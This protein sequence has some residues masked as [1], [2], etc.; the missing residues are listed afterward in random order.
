MKPLVSIGMPVKNGFIN[1]T[2][3]EI[4]L[5]KSLNS[6]LNQ[7]YDNLEIIISNSHSTDETKDFIEKASRLDKRI[8]IFDQTNNI[9]AAQNFEFVF[10]KANGKYFKWQA[11]DDIIS[12]NFIEK[13]LIFLE[14]NQDYICSSSKFY[15]EDNE[16]EIYSADLDE[17]LYK[18]LK[19]F[20]NIRFCSHN[21]FY[22]LIKKEYV[23]KTRYLSRD[24][25]A[26]DWMFDLELLLHGKFKTISE[27]YMILGAK[28]ISK[29]P[30]FL[31]EERFNNKII[32][33]YLPFY[34]FTKDLIMKTIFLDNLSIYQKISI[35]YSCLK[36]NL[37][38]LIKHRMN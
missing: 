4:N 33:R 26:W 15:W 22:G 8:K 3:N 36:T 28:G 38:F 5:F 9:S 17:N 20:F 27:G 13:N 19:K 34:E 6:V 14:K 32:Y 2:K 12:L 30:N 21:V 37:S 10:K 7:S 24:Y 31:K 18:R 16:R 25:L 23:S 29:L 1:K 35:Y 11:Q